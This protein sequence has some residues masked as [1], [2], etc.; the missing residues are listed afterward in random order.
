MWWII[1]GVVLYAAG[2]GTVLLFMAGA[3][4]L[5]EAY[6]EADRTGQ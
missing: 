2:I 5:N 1:G 6:D 4:M 3:K